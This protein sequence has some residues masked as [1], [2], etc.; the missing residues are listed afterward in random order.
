[1]GYRLEMSKVKYTACGGKLYGYT[2]TSKLKSYK[3]LKE[4]GFLNDIDDDHEDITFADWDGNP[5]IIMRNEDF[6]EFIKLYNEDCNNYDDTY[7]FHDKDW[8]INDKYIKELLK[9]DYVLLEWY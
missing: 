9:E 1:M 2:D 5:Q 8:I 3:W 4:K 7:L 6:K